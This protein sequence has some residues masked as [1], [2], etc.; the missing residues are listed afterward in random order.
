MSI[1]LLPFLPQTFKALANEGTL[2]R[3]HCCSWWCFFGAQTRATENE[4]CVFPCCANWETFVA[5]T[6]CFWT[7]SETSFL[8]WIQNLC[9]QQMLRAQANGE[10]FVPATMCLRWPRA[11]RSCVCD[12]SVR[13]RDH[14][15]ENEARKTETH[16]SM[17]NGNGFVSK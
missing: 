10:T 13:E 8:S 7:E 5:H 3:T 6:K 2:L 15:Y 1:C 4:F 11:F 17:K 12:P 14:L 9:P 16:E